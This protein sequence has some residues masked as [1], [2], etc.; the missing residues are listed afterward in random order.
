MIRPKEL[1]KKLIEMTPDAIAQIRPGTYDDFDLEQVLA[2]ME[3]SGEGTPAQQ[4][5]IKKLICRSPQL[6]D[7]LDYS[8]FFYEIMED[9]VR[10]EDG[11]DLLYWAVASLLYFI[12]RGH[13]LNT[14]HLWYYV[15]GFLYRGEARILPVFLKDL[16]A[17]TRIMPFELRELIDDFARLGC[18]ELAAA[19]DALGRERYQADWGSDD[20]R[21]ISPVDGGPC[22]ENFDETWRAEIL[23]L[24]QPDALGDEEEEKDIG[25]VNFGLTP[26]QFL[27][28]DELETFTET[29]ILTVP[30]I[31]HILFHNWPSRREASLNFLRIFQIMVNENILPDLSLLGDLL[32]ADQA[33]VFLFDH[34]GKTCGYCFESL[35]A[36]LLDETLCDEL[37]GDA[38]QALMEAAMQAPDRRQEIVQILKSVMA[39]AETGQTSEKIVT[40]IVADLL[41]TD[42]YELKAAVSE[43]FQRQQVSPVMIR[44]NS[45]TGKWTLPGLKPKTPPPPKSVVM[46]ACLNCD[47]VQEHPLNKLF[48][49]S[50]AF[51]ASETWDRYSMIFD[52][53]IVC[54]N[55]GAIDEYLVETLSVLRLLPEF[56]VSDRIEQAPL[57]SPKVFLIPPVEKTFMAGYTPVMFDQVRRHVLAQGL[58]SLDALSRGEYFRVLGR[59][60]ESLA[61]FRQAHQANP[62]DRTALL[63]LAM[64]EHDYGNSSRAKALYQQASR[65]SSK[66]LIFGNP[67]DPV[68]KAALEGLSLLNQGKRSPYPYPRN[69]NQETL[70]TLKSKGK[71]KGGK[72]RR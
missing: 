39:L 14:N 22:P 38:A 41:D 15:R 50:Q 3:K 18:Q 28:P 59:F 71:K 42:L 1:K 40:A 64:A 48:F 43:A 57:N 51:L 7:L 24:I 12:R 63:A 52:H 69:S 56:F 44:A 27:E 47:H 9:V 46:V 20:W 16:L 8:A 33:D 60:S 6:L 61:A 35:K 19:L 66:T 23:T 10:Y 54:S 72:R 13:S 21:E 32:A 53:E 58:D 68:E 29:L 37:R 34:L 45:F 31:L 17:Q 2:S 26:E 70:L 5:A 4:L 49:D 67:D 55:C 30:R 62:N 65:I 36:M 11:Q 25:L